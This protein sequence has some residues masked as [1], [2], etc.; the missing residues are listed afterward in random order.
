[1]TVE[2]EHLLLVPLSLGQMRRWIRNPRQTAGELGASA[3]DQSLLHRFSAS[4]IYR[5]KISLMEDDPQHWWLSTYF[6]M[7]RREDR[8]IVGELGFKGLARPG[9]T[10]LGYGTH[11]PYEHRGYMTEAVTA[12]SDWA[13]R[14]REV[15]L[16]RITARTRAE[17]YASQRVLYRSGF[18]Q[19][20]LDCGIYY[21]SKEASR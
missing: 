10:E 21:W 5:A 20:Y 2:T 18:S 14:Q 16:T 6:Q 11:P 12:L 13:L 19:L 4:R 9:E 17:N 8:Q 1:M 3:P 7:I 15:P